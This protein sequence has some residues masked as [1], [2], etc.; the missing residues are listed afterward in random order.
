MIVFGANAT[1]E[2]IA[3]P[4]DGVWKVTDVAEVVFFL[5]IRDDGPRWNLVVHHFCSEGSDSVGLDLDAV[6]KVID[7]V[8]GA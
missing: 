2:I 3:D 7:L 6:A 4:A 8:V 1:C 5:G